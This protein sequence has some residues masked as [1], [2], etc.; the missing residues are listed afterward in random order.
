MDVALILPLRRWLREQRLDT[1][2]GYLPAVASL[3][4]VAGAERHGRGGNPTGISLPTVHG[5]YSASRYSA[6]P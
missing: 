3:D 6:T 1:S 2:R 4:C 5:L